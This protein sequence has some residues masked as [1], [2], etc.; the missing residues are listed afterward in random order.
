LNRTGG[1][2]T[3]NGSA[4]FQVTFSK[5]ALGTPYHFRIQLTDSHGSEFKMIVRS[6]CATVA[7]CETGN[8]NGV[9]TWEGATTYVAGAGCCSDAS[10]P[11]SSVYVEVTRVAPQLTCSSFTVSFSNF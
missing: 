7:Q 11:A 10:P 2:A 5:P 3:A 4:W 8:G 6:A 9:T 1:I